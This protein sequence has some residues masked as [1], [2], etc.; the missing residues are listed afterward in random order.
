M[1]LDLALTAGVDAGRHREEAAREPA[2]CKCCKASRGKGPVTI[3][4][5]NR[6]GA[7]PRRGCDVDA[8]APIAKLRVAAVLEEAS[9][10]LLQVVRETTDLGG[11]RQSGAAN[12]AER[13]LPHQDALRGF[14]PV[15]AED[16]DGCGVEIAGC[17]RRFRKAGRN[18]R[19][20]DIEIVDAEADAG[21]DL[22]GSETG[23]SLERRAIEREIG[24]VIGETEC[25]A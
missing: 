24:V 1:P 22:A 17:K 5:G 8:A 23:G 19:A 11:E 9:L 18:K 2:R 10:G 15:D 3:D 7:A 12:L 21:A 14:G 6:A 16:L 20:F 4:G 13:A 25:L